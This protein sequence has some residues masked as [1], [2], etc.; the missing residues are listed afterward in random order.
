MSFVLGWKLVLI[1]SSHGIFLLL[2][3]IALGE[4]CLGL[5]LDRSEENSKPLPSMVEGQ[6]MIEKGRECLTALGGTCKWSGFRR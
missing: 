5:S 3:A 6:E 1:H 2:E 4:G